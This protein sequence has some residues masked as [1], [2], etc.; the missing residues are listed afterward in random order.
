M[1]QLDPSIRF[2]FSFLAEI[3]RE[4]LIIEHPHCL[5]RRHF[6]FTKYSVNC[7]LLILGQIQ[8]SKVDCAI[9]HSPNWVLINEH[10]TGSK[11]SEA[12]VTFVHLAGE[13]CLGAV[14]GLK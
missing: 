3:G 8:I 5:P 10:A 6:K 4:V 12:H 7:S 9:T 13:V 11:C 1:E 14:A 2:V